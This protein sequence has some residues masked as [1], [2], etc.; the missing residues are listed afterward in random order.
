MVELPGVE[1][2][3]TDDLFTW[4]IKKIEACS[5][6]KSATP[7]LSGSRKKD[8][9]NQTRPSQPNRPWVVPGNNASEMKRK[10]NLQPPDC[11]LI[12]CQRVRKTNPVAKKTKSGRPLI[13]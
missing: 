8:L 3:R 2:I 10:K 1:E 13:F 7:A 9:T 11:R 6:P 12:F 4:P 5:P